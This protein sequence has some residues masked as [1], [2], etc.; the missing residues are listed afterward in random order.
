M[1]DCTRTLHMGH[2]CT[3]AAHSAQ[4]I[5]RPQ[6]R[7]TVLLSASLHILHARMSLSRL[8]SNKTSISVVTAQCTSTVHCSNCSLVKCHFNTNC[9]WVN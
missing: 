3:V 8:F 4:H 6:G 1:L 7:K 9:Q 5:R 2:S